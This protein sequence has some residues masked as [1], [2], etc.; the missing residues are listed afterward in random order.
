MQTVRQSRTGTRRCARAL[1]AGPAARSRSPRG[2]RCHPAPRPTGCGRGAARRPSTGCRRSRATPRRP[3]A[4]PRRAAAG[5]G[6]VR[7]VGPVVHR[8]AAPPGSGADRGGERA[9][10]VRR[11]DPRPQHAVAE[12]SAPAQSE[13]ERRVAAGGAG[14]ALGEVRQHALARA[15]PSISP[16]N[17]RVRCHCAGGVQ[18]RSGRAARTGATAAASSSSTAAGGTRATNARTRPILAASRSRSAPQE[19]RPD[20]EVR[21]WVRARRPVYER[22]RPA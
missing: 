1:R 15:S 14:Q 20:T 12:P 5:Q 9:R 3:G 11:I 6:E 13:L 18:R 7:A 22:V 16:R 21:T 4:G 19:R 8:D 17:A 10:A 2:P